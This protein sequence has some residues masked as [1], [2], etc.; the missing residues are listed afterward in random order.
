[1]KAVK[2]KVTAVVMSGLL[3]CSCS[4]INPGD[5]QEPAPAGK[6]LVMEVDSGL[7]AD[8]LSES[9]AFAKQVEKLSGGALKI[10]VKAAATDIN[11]LSQGSCDLAFLSS[12][13]AARADDVFSMLSLPF[14]YD[15]ASHM[16][17]ALNSTEMT[18]ILSRKLAPGNL[19]P[20]A[21]L[22]NG[23][24]CVVTD[25]GL[26]R[27]PSDFK[28]LLMAADMD[29]TGSLNVFQM[30]GTAIA[31]YPAQSAVKAFNSRQEVK[32]QDGKLV[33]R[34]DAV[35]LALEQVQ[36]LLA[37]PQGLFLIRTSHA[38]AP[39]WL[40]ANAQ[41]ISQLSDYEQAVLKEAT[42]SLIAEMEESWQEKEDGL[43]QQF[44][45]EGITTVDAERPEFAAAVYEIV[46]STSIPKYFDRHI[47]RIIQL[48]ID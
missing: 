13:Q 31:A 48:F 1:M 4:P 16:S 40:L 19:V 23:N 21:A 35:E 39:I 9:E 38:I 25:K 14:L 43:V 11:C 27:V 32:D 34:V 33:G 22:Y 3:M 26:L 24:R 7:G 20:M 8:V 47:Y 45:T 37:D 44:K 5:E 29:K 17:L 36:E 18:G 41:T 2:Q 46:D 30:F 10:D 15:D 42:A 6:T 28:K 12:G